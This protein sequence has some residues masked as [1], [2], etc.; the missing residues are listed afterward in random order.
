MLVPYHVGSIAGGGYPPDY[1][2]ND[3]YRATFI[4]MDVRSIKERLTL[5]GEQQILSIDVDY[6]WLPFKE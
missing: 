1:F 6:I 4:P 5:V 2:L 3:R